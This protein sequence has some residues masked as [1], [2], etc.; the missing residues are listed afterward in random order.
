MKPVQHVS[1][2]FF[3]RPCASSAVELQGRGITEVV[4]LGRGSPAVLAL[5]SGIQDYR[6]ELIRFVN[7][8]VL[9]G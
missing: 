7:V 6:P 5:E 4:R 3:P 2:A 8:K 1:G 9:V